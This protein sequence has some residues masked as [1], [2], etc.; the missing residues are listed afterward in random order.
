[1]RTAAWGMWGILLLLPLVAL[2]QE[3]PRRPVSYVSPVVSAD[4]T[5]LFFIADEPNPATAGAINPDNLYFAR[6]NGSDLRRL[7]HNGAMLPH[8]R[9]GADG[10]IT[11]AGTGADSGNV[12]A[13]K[14]DG[15]GRRLVATVRGRS[16]VLSPDGTKVAY[17]VGP[18]R[19]AEIWVANADSSNA[20]RVAGGSRT[21]AWNPAWSPDG[22]TLAYTFGD[23]ARALQV[24]I[25]KVDGA[26]RDSAVTDTLD[27][28]HRA[29][30][31]AWSP[32]GTR[33]AVQW[34][35]EG[36]RG[37][38]IAVV[39][40]PTRQMTVLDAPP[41]DG[42]DAVLDEVPS[43]FPDGKRIVF[44]SNRGGNV[45]VW[46]IGVDGTGLRQLTGTVQPE[47]EKHGP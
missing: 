26:I 6:A 43:W 46:S 14:P 20:R 39:D 27:R 7:T 41:P 19:E 10:W 34:S 47:G 31:P 36:G 4:G 25:V 22:R 13:I 5:A 42:I 37:S 16:P 44:Q 11:F 29:Q 9:G 18:W 17:L 1:M 38:R 3:A 30:M 35:T 8:W 2:A 32:D 23:S 15:T 28:K 21:S 12:F 24:H 40:L 45:D 33:L